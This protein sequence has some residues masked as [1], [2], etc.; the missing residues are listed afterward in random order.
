MSELEAGQE[1]DKAVALALG[2]RRD[3]LIDIICHFRPSTDIADA[4]K[5]VA[6]MEKR[7]WKWQAFSVTDGLPFYTFNFGRHLDG[8]NRGTDP[9]SIEMAICRAALAALKGTT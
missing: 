8:D 1:M 3:E 9:T 2:R 7:G 4:F 6:E 5:V